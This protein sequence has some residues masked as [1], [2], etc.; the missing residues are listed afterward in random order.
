MEPID[1]ERTSA[2][3]RIRSVVLLL[4]FVVV[5]GAVVAGTLGVIVIAVASFV[6][7]ALE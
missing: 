2:L 5:L 1:D 3:R 7:Q 6:D 4:L